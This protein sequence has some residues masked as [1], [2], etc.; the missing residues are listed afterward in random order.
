[1]VLGESA[2]PTTGM[3]IACIGGTGFSLSTPACGRIFSHVL[4][5][6]S[7]VIN[8]PHLGRER[9]MMRVEGCHETVRC[10]HPCTPPRRGENSTDLDPGGGGI[11]PPPGTLR[12]ALPRARGLLQTQPHP[13]S[14]KYLNR[15]RRMAIPRE[16]DGHQQA[17]C[18]PARRRQNRRRRQ[19]QEPHPPRRKQAV[20][21]T[22][23]AQIPRPDGQ[24]A[25]FTTVSVTC[26]GYCREWCTAVCATTPFASS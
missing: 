26:D 24:S 19:W 9:S 7:P 17:N 23:R 2:C 20:H 12:R 6:G 14:R 10:P 4:R 11:E 1:M 8:R 25:R 3:S 16:P 5:K 15:C 18:E 21:H 13:R 22:D